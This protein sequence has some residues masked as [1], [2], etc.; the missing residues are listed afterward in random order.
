MQFP[1]SGMLGSTSQSL[2]LLTP[3]RLQRLISQHTLNRKLLFSYFSYEQQ[4]YFFSSETRIC[5]SKL[6]TKHLL[7][8]ALWKVSEEFRRQKQKKFYSFTW[9]GR[10][11]FYNCLQDAKWKVLRQFI[12]GYHL[13]V[14]LNSSLELYTY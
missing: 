6:N 13:R 11:A 2:S 3:K 7:Y 4:H 9:G 10:M 5:D 8:K 12:I 14:H 1:Q